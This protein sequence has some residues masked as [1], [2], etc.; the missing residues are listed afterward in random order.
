MSDA[1]STVTGSSDP[2]TADPLARIAEAVRSLMPGPAS[3]ELLAQIAAILASTVP[4]DIE[5]VTLENAQLQHELE[6]VQSVDSLTGLRNRQR[7]FEDLRREVAA[8]RRYDSPLSLVVLDVD[9]LRTVN[10]TRGYDAG[11]RLLLTL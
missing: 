10:E 2:A 1:S 6:L 11:D 4:D 7:F 5:Q 9:G 3:D 8:A